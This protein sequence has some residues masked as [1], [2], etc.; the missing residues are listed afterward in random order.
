MSTASVPPPP[1]PPTA[2]AFP[3]K[4]YNAVV[5]SADK[6]VPEK[7]RPLWNHAAGSFIQQNIE[8]KIT[9]NYLPYF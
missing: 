5:S 6:F 7:F 8:K 2:M 9:N 1:P 3:S 4:V